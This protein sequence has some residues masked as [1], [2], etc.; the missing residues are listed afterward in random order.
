MNS[1]KIIWIAFALMVLLQFWVPASVIRKKQNIL[2]NGR[3]FKF[4][5]A[6]VDPSDYLRGKYVYL[7]FNRN[8]F[9]TRDTKE[10]K[11]GDEIYVDIGTDSAGFAKIIAINS[12]PKKA[13]K[14]HIKTTVSYM[15]YE[16][17]NGRE[18]HIDWPFDRFY[19][20]ESKAPLAEKAYNQSRMDSSI[21]SYALVKVKNG[22]AVIENLFI[23]D[24]PIDEY[25][26]K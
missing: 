16:T 22:D 18:V 24:Q 8:S 19:M 17:G 20:E 13:G 10:W 1:K 25:I 4:R 12:D 3:A 23:N 21:V 15:S 7:D 9:F 5:T 26:K 6:P 2:D 14:D 11:S